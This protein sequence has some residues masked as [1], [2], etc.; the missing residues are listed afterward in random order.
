MIT[1]VRLKNW[2]SHRETELAFGDGTNV[3]VGMM[4]AG[5]SSVMEGITYALFGTIPAVQS[6][7]I[8][9]EDLITS[10]PRPLDSAEVEVRFLSPDGDEFLVKRII[11][12]GTGTALSELR[13]ANG[14]LI[15]GPNASRVTEAIRSILDLDYD[16]FERA[17]YS[18]QNR[19][20]YFLTLQRGKRMESIDEL[21]GINKLEKARKS[22][23]TMVNRITE[24]AS[25]RDIAASNLKQD[26]SIQNLSTYTQELSKLESSNQ[27]IS[28][29]LQQLRSELE[30]IRAQ[31][32]Q[33]RK[34]EYELRKLEQ[35]K[36]SLE[37]AIDA[38]KK[39]IDEI[40]QRLGVYA[41][42]SVDVMR[43]E[44][45]E[46][47]SVHSK[48]VSNLNSLRSDFTAAASGLQSLETRKTLTSGSIEKLAAAIARKREA[49]AKL[50]GMKPDELPGLVERLQAE[51][52]QVEDALAGHRARINDL[53][54]VVEEL[55]SA[56]AACPVCDSPLN[57]ERK[58]ELLEKRR[59]DMKELTARVDEAEV[60]SSKLG[61]QLHQT[62]ELHRRAMLLGKETEDLPRLEAEHSD[63]SKQLLDVEK[64]IP[65]QHEKSEK[66]AIEVECTRNKAD[67]LGE[68][69]SNTKQL[70]QNRT[71]LDAR[72]LEQNLKLEEI[73][74][75]QEKIELIRRT[76]D[77]TKAE[78]IRKR[79]EELVGSQ[80]RLQAEFL[81]KEQLIAEKRKLVDSIQEKI[82]LIKRYEVEVKRLREAAQ[83]MGTIQTALARTQTAMRRMFIEGVNLVMND[84]WEGIYPYGD[85]VGIRLDVEEG[86]R[87]DYV[88]QLRDRSGNWIPVDGIASGGE[89]TDA[90]L[91]LR[92]SFSMVLA[93]K[94]KWIVFDEPTHNLDAEGI[95]ELAKVLRERL[96][97]VVRQ[98]L[99]ITHEERL[100]S[101]VSGYL[102]R[103]HRNKREDEPTKVERATTPELY[104]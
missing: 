36:R 6:R 5:K 12:R 94:L 74:R 59:K 48:K 80:E 69:L 21:L 17:I 4:G 53:N 51:L 93:P 84:L 73:S 62:R 75:T 16:L 37:G 22:I 27:E 50:D 42:S 71:D 86:E 14:E 9:L 24:R 65:K 43:E 23:G 82:E 90:A 7:R 2:K 60:R 11:E 57:E 33:F 45:S 31:D 103:F 102:Y 39:N 41:G 104:E 40:N 10:R 49:K 68:K 67:E 56:G 18:E 66:L 34:L 70:L 87:G 78:A 38:L 95:R 81:G 79:V 100:E 30:S 8:K 98:I 58:R 44:I 96:P 29:K 89:R 77:E 55:T 63:T 20:D 35:S 26:Q 92:I 61:E 85:F 72:I 47:E 25:E 99:L 19:L 3:L 91:A 15:E 52:R 13:K 76:Y 83:A 28:T 88:L 54:L 1:F 32:E 64:E 101:A 97:E 46:L